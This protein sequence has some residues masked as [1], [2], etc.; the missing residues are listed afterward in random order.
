[1]QQFKV[2]D[3][4]AMSGQLLQKAASQTKTREAT[5]LLDLY[6]R[7]GVEPRLWMYDMLFQMHAR[8]GNLD[9]VFA[10][11]DK[12][13]EQHGLKLERFVPCH[14]IV[15]AFSL[16]LKNSHSAHFTDASASMMHLA[17]PGACQPRQCCCC[18]CS[19]G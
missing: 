13:T 7:S 15:M 16:S 6:H 14:F 8:R 9:A 3:L 18:T 1:M 5:W 12:M 4:L 2:S 19:Q 11:K 17:L 10:V